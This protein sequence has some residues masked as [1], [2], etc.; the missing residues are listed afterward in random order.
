MISFNELVSWFSIHTFIYHKN[1]SVLNKRK[2]YAL[3]NCMQFLN[4]TK[5]TYYIF[6]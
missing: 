3:G 4:E 6:F 2:K 1:I 5:Y